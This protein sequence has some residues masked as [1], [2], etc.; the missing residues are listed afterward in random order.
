MKQTVPLKQV[1]KESAEL[2]KAIDQAIRQD[3]LFKSQGLR[4]SDIA[5]RFGIGRHRLNDVLSNNTNGMS[6]P[7]YINA[8]RMEEADRLYWSELHLNFAEIA[9]MVG[10]TPSNFRNQFKRKYGMNPR[11]YRRRHH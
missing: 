1:E 2:F 7:Q 4:R 3:K 6:F 5:Q 8:I 10:L 9:Y 11:D